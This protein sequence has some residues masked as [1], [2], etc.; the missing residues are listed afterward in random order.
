MFF[1]QHPRA[2]DVGGIVGKDRY[3]GLPKDLTVV[4]V[5]GHDMDRT[6]GDCIARVERSAGGCRA[7]CIWG[8][9]RDEY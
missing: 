7:P 4:E 5:F 1:Y 8:A 9:V 6:S 3:L 2:Q